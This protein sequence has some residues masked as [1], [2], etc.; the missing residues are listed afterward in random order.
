M[1]Q[2]IN[3]RAENYLVGDDTEVWICAEELTPLAP[4]PTEY[5]MPCYSD[6]FDLLTLSST[7]GLVP[8]SIK[9]PHGRRL[10]TADGNC[11]VVNANSFPIDPVAGTSVIPVGVTTLPVSPMS[12]LLTKGAISPYYTTIK[13]Y[14]Y[15]P[16]YSA[17]DVSV[18]KDWD[19]VAFRNF[20]TNG[21]ELMKKTKLKLDFS[22]SGEENLND[23][24]LALVRKCVNSASSFLK[25]LIVRPSF[26]AIEANYY[27]KTDDLSTKNLA[28][29]EAKF[30]FVYA[31]ELTEYDL[32]AR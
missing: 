26:Q 11:V 28:A 10:I 30:S 22:L 31:G 24:M 4:D 20:K 6:S 29:V 18:K 5:T 9:I 1:A 16:Y 3:D 23:S 14:N 19:T 12:T 7:S 21:A 2:R 8:T 27:V 32:R 15:L 13:F 25:I 17:N